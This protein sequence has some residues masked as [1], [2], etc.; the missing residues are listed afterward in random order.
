MNLR[1][2]VVIVI[3]SFSGAASSADKP[4]EQ[5]KPSPD[6]SKRCSALASN[7]RMAALMRLLTKSVR[8]A[9]FVRTGK[10]KKT[11]CKAGGICTVNQT[12][13]RET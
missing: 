6:T 11:Q 10:I 5:L 3:L 12:I 9:E 7:D 8:Q 4:V 13:T 1:L 2:S